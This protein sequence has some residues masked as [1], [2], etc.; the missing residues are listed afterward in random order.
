MSAKDPSRAT[1]GNIVV[2]CFFSYLPLP[3]SKLCEDKGH[4]CNDFRV[5]NVILR[6]FG[7]SKTRMFVR[8]AVHD[9][10]PCL[11]ELLR[12]FFPGLSPH[13]FHT[14][15][16]ALNLDNF[17]CTMLAHQSEYLGLYVQCST[18]TCPIFRTPVCLRYLRAFVEPL[19]RATLV[20]ATLVRATLLYSFSVSRDPSFQW[21]SIF[22]HPPYGKPG[23]PSKRWETTLF[24]SHVNSS[25][26]RNGDFAGHW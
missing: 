25:G 24:F 17:F 14:A 22:R 21:A 18:F 19:V 16:V 12:Y 15:H 7:A 1:L 6:G 5:P 9:V 8:F 20:R 10:P 13:K 3:I 4:L 2:P 26:T 23:R 11:L